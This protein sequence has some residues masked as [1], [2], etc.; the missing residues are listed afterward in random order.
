MNKLDMERSDLDFL[1]GLHNMKLYFAEHL[2][3]F[4][5]SFHQSK[6][7]GSPVNRHVD[8]RQ[9]KWNGA[10]VIFV[11]VREDQRADVLA[12]LLEIS[13]IRCNDVDAEEF[14]VGKHHTRIHHDDVIP[15]ADGHRVHTELAES[16]EWNH[17]QLLIGHSCSG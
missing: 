11:A 3:L 6:C 8:L 2:V 17:L 1:G 16:S 15:V 14:R 10:N 12:V 13:E 5:P 4:E 7:K 9:E